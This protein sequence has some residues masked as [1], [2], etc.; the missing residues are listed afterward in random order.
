[1]CGNKSRVGD[2][3]EY[4]LLDRRGYKRAKDVGTGFADGQGRRRLWIAGRS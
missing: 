1:M 3:S 2:K 4:R